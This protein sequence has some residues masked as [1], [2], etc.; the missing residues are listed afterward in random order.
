[1]LQKKVENLLNVDA[2][3][4]AK[5]IV[6]VILRDCIVLNYV[7]VLVHVFEKPYQLFRMLSYLELKISY[8]KTVYLKDM[9]QV[10]IFLNV[11][12]T[13]WNILF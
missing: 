7:L 1:M 9:K 4:R 11:K 12:F 10:Y 3:K 5:L 8:F 2:E 6:N 13:S